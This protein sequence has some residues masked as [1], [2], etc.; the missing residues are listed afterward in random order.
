MTTSIKNQNKT[1]ILLNDSEINILKN[2][3]LTDFQFRFMVPHTTYPFGNSSKASVLESILPG[4]NSI[5]SFANISSLFTPQQE[6]INIMETLKTQR[7]PFWFRVI[8]TRPG[9][10]INN[11]S[12]DTSTKTYSYQSFETNTMVTLEDYKITDDADEGT[13]V[14]VDVNLKKWADYGTSEY[15]IDSSDNTKVTKI[16]HRTNYNSLTTVTGTEKEWRTAALAN[17]LGWG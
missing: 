15:I 11:I 2:A 9:S 6:W 4:V 12:Y 3:G 13:D 16:S 1:V 7:F 17:L 5:Y 10:S 8:R 14:W